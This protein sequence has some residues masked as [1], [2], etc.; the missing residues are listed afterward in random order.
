MENKVTIKSFERRT[1]IR[2]NR[3]KLFRDKVNKFITEYKN[4]I[5]HADGLTKRIE[6]IEEEISEIRTLLEQKKKWMYVIKNRRG[7]DIYALERAIS[8]L[9]ECSA[10]MNEQELKQLHTIVNF[11]EIRKAQARE[12]NK[13]KNIHQN[14]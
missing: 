7:S 13:K 1:G 4:L 2:T 9:K 11:I 5:I 3:H 12:Y 8:D 6:N 14:K 10:I